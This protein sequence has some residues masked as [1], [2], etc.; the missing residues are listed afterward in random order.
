MRFHRT[1]SVI[2]VLTSRHSFITTLFRFTLLDATTP[3]PSHAPVVND[4]ELDMF[5]IWRVSVG[6]GTATMAEPVGSTRTPETVRTVTQLELDTDTG[7]MRVVTEFHSSRG[8]HVDVGEWFTPS[9]GHRSLFDRHMDSLRIYDRNEVN[10]SDVFIPNRN[11]WDNARLGFD[12]M[13]GFDFQSNSMTAAAFD[14]QAQ[15][16]A[17]AP[18]T[19]DLGQMIAADSL[20]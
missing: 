13:A 7:R 16:T 15:D 5:D 20:L 10:D 1:N 9:Q 12:D 2:F 8:V 6:E 11:P 14:W 18:D 19:Y 3:F 17:M 4:G